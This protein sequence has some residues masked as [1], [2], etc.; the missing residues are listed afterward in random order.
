MKKSNLEP[1]FFDSLDELRLVVEEA[2]E[3]LAEVQMDLLYLKSAI[4]ELKDHAKQS[5]SQSG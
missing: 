4:A 3:N 5:A 2:A 1:V